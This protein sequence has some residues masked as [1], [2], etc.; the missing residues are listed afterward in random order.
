MKPSSRTIPE[1]STYLVIGGV[2]DAQATGM[3]GF[4]GNLSVFRPIFK[5][6]AIQSECRLPW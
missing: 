2:S 6:N 3:S 1:V 5:T 4:S